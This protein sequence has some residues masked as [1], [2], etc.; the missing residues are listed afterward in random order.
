MSLLRKVG[1]LSPSEKAVLKELYRD[2]KPT[3]YKT[4]HQITGVSIVLWTH[5]S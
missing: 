5:F 2:F 3:L 1:K 4:V